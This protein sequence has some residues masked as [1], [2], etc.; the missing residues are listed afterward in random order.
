MIRSCIP[1]MVIVPPTFDLDDNKFSMRTRT[2]S[3]SRC[4]KHLMMIKWF[5]KSLFEGLLFLILLL[6]IFHRTMSCRWFWSLR[7][8]IELS[9]SSLSTAKF[10]ISIFCGSLEFICP[11]NA[12]LAKSY[13]SK[14]GL[15]LDTGR[16][17]QNH[18]GSRTYN[19]FMIFIRMI[20]FLLVVLAHLRISF[21]LNRYSIELNLI[22]WIF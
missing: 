22:F 13:L 3:T 18:N 9:A 21:I 19:Y 15:V 10:K 2:S 5:P 17:G 6:W 11:L 20:L 14:F 8:T 7:L 4:Y 12:T 16:H 1:C